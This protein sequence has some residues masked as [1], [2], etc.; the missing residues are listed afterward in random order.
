MD[1]DLKS[2]LKNEVRILNQLLAAQSIIHI[3]PNTK[4]LG[5]FLVQVL[6]TMPGVRSCCAC[7]RNEAEFIGDNS[8]FASELMA[9]LKDI[10]HD[11]NHITKILP[12]KENFV[13]FILQTTARQFG[14]VVL[15]I[16]SIEFENYKPATN[17]FINTIALNLENH[18]RNEE[19]ALYKDNLEELVKE[20]TAE[21]ELKVTDLRLAEKT[22][23]E[24]EGKFKGIYEASPI[25]IELYNHS[26]NLLDVNQKCI[27]ILGIVDQ[28]QLKQFNLFNDPNLDES[29]LDLLR[30]GETVRQEISF[31][32]D[33]VRELK[34][35]DTTKSGIIYLD[36]QITPVK[37]NGIGPIIGY[38][39]H[40]RD[41]T[42]QKFRDD[43]RDMTSRLILLINSPGDFRER[44]S[45]LIASL[46]G[47]SG[48]EAVGIRLHLGEDY[49]YYATNGF[50]ARFVQAENH[51]CVYDSTGNIL[52][53]EVG[54]PVL[55][56]M[57]GNVLCGRF[58]A[59]KSFFTKNGSFWS[60]NTSA[61]LASTTEA[62]RQARTRNRCN[63]EGYES[64]ALVPL[65]AGNQ[66]FGLIQYN[67]KRKD[68]FTL[69]MIE[70]FERTA[71]SLSYALSQRQAEEELKK[72][73][74]LLAET[75]R[76]GKVGGW[77]F[78]ID[79]GKQIWTDEVYRI[80]EVESGFVPDLI[81][82]INFYAPSSL[83]IVENAVKQAIEHD[84]SFDLELDIITAKGNIRSVHAIGE[85]DLQN[86]RIFGF[87][88]DITKRKQTELALKDSEQRY[89]LL[90]QNLNSLF[91]VYEIVL[92]K[93]GKPFD[94]R[95]LQVNSAY[96]EFTGLK[97]SDL[98]G[99]TLLEVFPATEEYWI[100]KIA[101]VAMS[102]IPSNYENYSKILD[103]Y[104]ELS[105]YSPEH[106]QIALLGHD[107]TYRKKAEVDIKNKNIEL[108]ELNA[109]K[110]KFF[111]IIAH[112]LRSPFN[113]FLG[114]TRLMAEETSDFT[115]IEL[116]E[117]S[118]KMQSSANNLY[119]LLENLLE[120]SRIQRGLTEF[121]PQVCQLNDIIKQ[122]IEIERDFAKQKSIE[123]I[124]NIV[125]TY[126]AKIDISMIDTVLRNLITNAIKFTPRG[127]KIEI[128][129]SSDELHLEGGAHL[130]TCI[131]IKDNGIGM[132]A[133]TLEKL[134]KIDENVT[135][136]GT[137]KEP[138]T[139]LGLL[140]CKEFVEKHGG[141]IWAESEEGKGST[142]YLTL[143]KDVQ[144]I[145]S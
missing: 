25:G 131:Y 36:F 102:G 27:D 83:P 110:D 41:I 35:Y 6:K 91:S 31:D 130:A 116:Q 49:P 100:E 8:D 4:K 48:C 67:D 15:S 14:F 57:C 42:E 132:N 16:D 139:G 22:I 141:R 93:N 33:K 126:E 20:R 90:F 50:P 82:G 94:L 106:N 72:S 101:D 96:E 43:E 26:G 12:T 105:I 103:K 120:W 55:E 138:S 3:F 97:S 121:K 28:S 111:S 19:L 59:E 87:F 86:R 13:A 136:P 77:E 51:L 123:I 62:D 9:T 79:T 92:D 68:R 1:N 30:N 66:V 24:S 63:G 122:N 144:P 21:L 99:K 125:N 37:I 137:E 69:L 112:D 5:E 53:D 70:H 140:L 129:V 88:Q 117:I 39:T 74:Q 107:I 29:L 11:K 52:H 114:L 64:V 46:K 58:D 113:G 47:W 108:A 73:R 143:P 56:C 40:I 95:F 109:S 104:L 60:N 145:K 18:W 98:I 84:E 133:D 81:N 118:Q 54:N 65:K 142:F 2:D 10:P 7:L 23:R 80:H 34:L 38:L 45:E 76:I 61:L 32:F 17:N 124:L 115:L 89:K 75:E 127:G 78:N 134:F 71:D 135:R 119:K 44:I 85:A 128:G